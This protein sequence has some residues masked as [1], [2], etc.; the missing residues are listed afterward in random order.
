MNTNDQQDPNRAA[1]S[2]EP[3]EDALTELMKGHLDDI[4]G[5]L[6]A[7]HNSWKQTV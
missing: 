6:A 1:G 4:V 3:N 7:R 5:G 2:G